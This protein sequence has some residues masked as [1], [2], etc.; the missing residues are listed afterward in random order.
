LSGTC[1][2]AM[3]SS[4]GSLTN[5][6]CS[7]KETVGVFVVNQMLAMMEIVVRVMLTSPQVSL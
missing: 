1:G 7:L 2:R 5:Q 3:S 4:D 6:R